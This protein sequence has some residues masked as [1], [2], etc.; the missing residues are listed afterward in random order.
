MFTMRS[1]R[2]LLT[3]GSITGVLA[4]G[5]LA[6]H[7]PAAGAIVTAADQ[8][9]GIIYGYNYWGLQYFNEYE[10]T[11]GEPSLYGELAWNRVVYYGHLLSLNNC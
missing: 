3:A 9:G 7:A 2:K 11:G 8:C 10:R 5:G 4:L 6:A 1:L